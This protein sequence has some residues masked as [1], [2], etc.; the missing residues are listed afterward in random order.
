MI[1]QKLLLRFLSV[2]LTVLLGSGAFAS[3]ASANANNAGGGA[4]AKRPPNIVIMFMDDMGYGDANV[5]GG[6][7]YSTPNIDKLADQGMRFTNF[8]AAQP[9]CTASRAGLLT[10]T[11]PNRNGFYGAF[12]PEFK[13]GLSS[14]DET[15]AGMLKKKGYATGIIGKWGL[16]DAKKLLPLEHGF[17]YYF[18]LPYS[19]DMW[20]HDWN[21]KLITST[22]G[23]SVAIHRKSKFPPLPLMEGNRT[24]NKP[25][26]YKVVRHINSLHD[27]GMLTTWYTQKA[28]NFIKR[29]KHQQFFLYL[30]HTM[31]HVPIA[32]SNKFK[33]K[34]QQGLYGDVME[35]IDWSVGQV[36]K[37]L[38]K[39]GLKNNTL[40]I[41]S[42]DN[43]PSIK[44]GNWAG[45]AGGLREG[46]QTT[47]EGGQR[48]PAIMRWP[49]VIPA[50]TIDNKL[51]STLDIMP[52]AAAI[53]GAPLPKE[54]I[55]GVNILPLLKGE[56][57]ANPRN[58]FYYYSIKMTWKP[59]AKGSGNWCCHISMFQIKTRYLAEM[60]NRGKCI[61]PRADYLY[62]ICDGIRASVIM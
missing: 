52:T 41:F 46:K 43:G 21:G 40:V 25:V 17:D 26:H 19:N 36:M 22:K 37:T 31:P 33:G 45:S 49:G 34:S 24:K 18:G 50:G 28:V 44:F 56:R 27:Q 13:G 15:I 3:S 4:K 59:C 10:G 38:K 61:K 2:L 5:Y 16:G 23:R 7:D 8:Y 58:H 42:S 60:A 39:N 30:A 35:E 57:G 11:Y 55:D 48:E 9:I 51:A 12:G 32:V 62:T 29:H 6:I 14:K 53:T 47:F 1:Y 20:P 54:K